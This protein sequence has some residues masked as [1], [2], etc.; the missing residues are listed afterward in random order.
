MCC[1]DCQPSV[2]VCVVLSQDLF[3][4]SSHSISFGLPLVKSFRTIRIHLSLLIR[5]IHLKQFL[6]RG[7]KPR[8][9]KMKNRSKAFLTKETRWDSRRRPGTKIVERITERPLSHLDFC[10]GPVFVKETISRRPLS[11][12]SSRPLWK[13][14]FFCLWLL[15]IQRCHSKRLV[16]TGSSIPICLQ[17]FFP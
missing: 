4:Y 15:G 17:L 9:K 3:R 12:L 13:V 10:C 7:W 11:P 2:V 5:K 1:G 8:E 14:P 6:K 16:R